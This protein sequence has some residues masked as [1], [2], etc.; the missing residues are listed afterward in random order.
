MRACMAGDFDRAE[1]FAREAF[2]IGQRAQDP[3]A[4]Q[5]FT[6]Q[7]FGIR[8][9]G[10][11]LKDVEL[12]A[13]DFATEYTAVPAW[14]AGMALLYADLGN[15]VA[16]RQE[17][18][19]LAAKDFADIV[20]DADWMVTMASL[21]QTVR[22]LARR[23][24]R[25]AALRDV[26]SLRRAL[27]R[28]RPWPRLSGIGRTLLGSAGG[29]AATLGGGGGHFTAA[30]TRNRQLGAKSLVALT[31]REH[32]LMFL[33]RNQNGDRGRAMRIFDETLALAR[34]L[35]MQDLIGRVLAFQ[36]AAAT[37]PP[38]LE[39]LPGRGGRSGPVRRLGSRSRSRRG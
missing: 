9:G 19:Q 27:R 4:A 37:M 17:F 20:R 39:V 1:A 38:S 26:A 3:D 36:E 25:G 28:G 6:V 30:I 14:R 12:P 32:A 23:S 22:L 5:C 29:S 34:Q 13:R 18:E 2:E 15:E 11:G 8:S 31:Q 16:A 10:K 24:A 33:A 35:G 21:A 7:I